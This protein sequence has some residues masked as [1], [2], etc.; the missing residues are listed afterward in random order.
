[1]T[2]LKKKK[3]SKGRLPENADEIYQKVK[4]IQNPI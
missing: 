3:N 1:M 4:L 2:V